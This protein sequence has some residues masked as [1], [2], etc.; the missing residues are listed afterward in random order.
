MKTLEHILD[1]N[2]CLKGQDPQNKINITF[3]SLK[4]LI[5]SVDSIFPSLYPFFFLGP[6]ITISSL[7]FFKSLR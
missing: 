6:L 5:I 3:L 1:I 4:M 2:E 7:I